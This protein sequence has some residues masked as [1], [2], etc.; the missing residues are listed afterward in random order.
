MKKTILVLISLASLVIISLIAYI[1][2]LG[3]MP[4]LSDLVKTNKPKDLKVIYT[5]EDYSGFM[6]KTKTNYVS[7]EGDPIPEESI[8]FSGQK[9][10]E[11]SF[12]S[13]EA[14]ARIN[15]DKWAYMPFYNVQIKFNNDGTFEL[16][17]NLRMDRID[18]F[19][20]S[21]GG[22]GYSKKDVDKGLGYLGIIK[23]DPPIYAKASVAVQNNEPIIHLEKLEVG[24]IRIP[25]EKFDS[26]SFLVKITKQ[27]FS[28][29]P[30]FY[31]QSFILS[32]DMASFKGKIP[33]KLEVQLTK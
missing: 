8:I 28:R 9:D 21:I 16:S 17:S 15:Y 26:D 10:L 13:A 31:T 18:G 11:T 20:Q 27:V 30:G 19:I 33:E 7:L 6:A 24:K 12:T 22:V 5:E 14:S 32:E 1:T 3:L 4:G 29:I 25:I 2:Y 23:N